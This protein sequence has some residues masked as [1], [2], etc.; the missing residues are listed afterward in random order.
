[1]A[2]F[3]TI[4]DTKN[5]KLDLYCNSVIQKNGGSYANLTQ[6]ISVEVSNNDFYIIPFVSNLSRNIVLVDN[7]EIKFL[8]E[9]TYCVN[10]SARGTNLT[11]SSSND[12]PYV[13]QYFNLYDK[14]DVLLY[15]S[16]DQRVGVK[17]PFS[18]VGITSFSMILPNTLIFRAPVDSYLVCLLKKTGVEPANV[19]FNIINCTVFKI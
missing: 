6:Q 12:E 18:Q 7:A 14:N 17:F 8:E 9:G 16:F 1:M 15:S 4:L 11:Y 5:D 10:I 19:S 2:D 3:S 13:N